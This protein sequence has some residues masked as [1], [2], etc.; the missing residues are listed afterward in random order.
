[1]SICTDIYMVTHTHTHTYICLYYF[2]GF[3]DLQNNLKQRL[4]FFI[5]NWNKIQ[6]KGKECYLLQTLLTFISHRLNVF[7]YIYC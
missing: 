3:M 4:T 2:P 1:M 7:S 5:L 6:C